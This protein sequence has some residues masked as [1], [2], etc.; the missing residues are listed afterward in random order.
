MN[1]DGDPSPTSPYN[2]IILSLSLS[3]VESSAWS[4]RL[5]A[6]SH[7]VDLNRTD[8]AIH[9][10]PFI[11]THTNIAFQRT[12][13]HNLPALSRRHLQHTNIKCNIGHGTQ[14]KHLTNKDK[15]LK[16]LT[17]RLRW[18]P[19]STGWGRTRREVWKNICA[20]WV[21]HQ[22]GRDQVCGMR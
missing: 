4:V 19:G 15:T 1:H 17:L 8:T 6:N 18:L 9:N 22:T 7:T 11:G 2:V 16:I 21:W 3:R 5:F 13:K 20:L 14:S 12:H 10:N